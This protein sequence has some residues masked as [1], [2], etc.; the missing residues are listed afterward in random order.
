MQ[1][2]VRDHHRW[3]GIIDVTFDRNNHQTYRGLQVQVIPREACGELSRNALVHLW[4]G[5][6]S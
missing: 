2:Q 3:E 1:K 4:D 5:P 6:L